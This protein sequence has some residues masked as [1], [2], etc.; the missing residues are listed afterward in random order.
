MRFRE[1]PPKEEK[2]VLHRTYKR[3]GTVYRE[4]DQEVLISGHYQTFS[5]VEIPNFYARSANGEIFVNPMEKVVTSITHVPLY[6]DWSDAN[7]GGST[8]SFV[9]EWPRSTHID[10]PVVEP[11]LDVQD[12]AVKRALADSSNAA[13]DSL[14][15][16]LEAKETLGTLHSIAIR[17]R[18]Y[19]RKAGYKQ[20]CY[21]LWKVKR[22]DDAIL[23][24]YL[25]IRYGFRPM[26]YEARGAWDALTAE[27]NR[28][29]TSRGFARTSDSSS[30]VTGRW[31]Y[32]PGQD[33]GI[34][35]D[36]LTDWSTTV[37][38]SCRAGV[39]SEID[40]RFSK[41]I[42]WGFNDPIQSMWQATKLSF[43]IDW[44]INVGD[45]IGALSPKL[46]IKQLASWA[47]IERKE[48][49]VTRTLSIKALYPDES[50]SW[51][52]GFC[53]TETVTRKRIPNPSVSLLPDINLRFN[54]L[55][56]VDAV[57]ILRSIWLPNRRRI[58]RFERS[59]KHA[60]R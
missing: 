15:S 47:T 39:L 49:K 53:R 43:M 45:T 25:E 4:E 38:L 54:P 57:A 17:A 6:L 55:K 21:D 31:S 59:M 56:L 41:A 36:S 9:G 29:E 37:D 30:Q 7:S 60:T 2:R 13:F 14:T 33:A 32:Y 34:N 28:R 35:Y 3:D 42:I 1:L 48:V 12:I 16:L 18:K 22:W 8:T 11:F 10:C 23:N 20:L 26:Y 24:Q 40:P 46:G 19:L 52:G 58:Q 50:L 44:V 5:D 51:A 27:L